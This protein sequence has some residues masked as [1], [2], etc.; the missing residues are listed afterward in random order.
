MTHGSQ[1]E[2][3]CV[4]WSGAPGNAG[5]WQEAEG[6]VSCGQG[7]LLWFSLGGTGEAGEAGLLL[8]SLNKFSELWG[9]GLSIVVWYRA[10]G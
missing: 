9:I 5:I 2:E 8:A 10:L 6:V 3:A 4:P 1:E 7:P